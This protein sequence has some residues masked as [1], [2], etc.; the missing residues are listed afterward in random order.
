MWISA[1]AFLTQNG[2]LVMC[3]FVCAHA[4]RSIMQSNCVVVH[5]AHVLQS[6]SCTYCIDFVIDSACSRSWLQ[7]YTAT[8]LLRRRLIDQDDV[9]RVSCFSRGRSLLRG[10]HHGRDL[11]PLSSLSTLST[12]A[13]FS[14]LL[15]PRCSQV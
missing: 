2:V 13:T 3:Q 12:L 9:Q 15:F 5:S 7:R 11:S 14:E 10:V 6:S 1:C 8:S 4:R